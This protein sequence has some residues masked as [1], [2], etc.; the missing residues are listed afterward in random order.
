[1]LRGCG[2]SVFIDIGGTADVVV[3]ST[4]AGSQSLESLVGLPYEVRH[5]SSFYL[6]PKG[7]RAE[8]NRCYEL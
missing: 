8:R 3:S 6:E 2:E 5:E 7:K 1:M 4:P